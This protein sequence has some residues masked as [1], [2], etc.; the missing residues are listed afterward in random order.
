MAWLAN[1]APTHKRA[2]SGIRASCNT[3]ARSIPRESSACGAAGVAEGANNSCGIDKPRSWSTGKTGIMPVLRRPGH[4]L[5]GRTVP[6][7]MRWAHAN[8]C[9]GH[10]PT[11][12]QI[13]FG[14]VTQR[15]EPI[16]PARGTSPGRSGGA[17]A[18]SRRIT[19]R[20]I[21]AATTA[22]SSALAGG[23]GRLDGRTDE[24]ERRVRVA[25]QGRDGSD[26]NHHDQGQHHGVLDRRRAIFLLEEIHQSLRH[27][28]HVCVSCLMLK[29]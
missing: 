4:H 6:D 12:K 20:A 29:V 9:V 15:A 22:D 7:E 16:G 1:A 14:R 25:A 19:H 27:C 21:L 28:A 26:A 13:A 10:S 11:Y 3:N 5:V 24:A 18:S 17:A 2:N 8:K 23:R